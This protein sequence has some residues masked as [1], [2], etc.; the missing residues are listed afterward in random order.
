[1]SPGSL[2]ASRDFRL[3]L[4]GQTTSQLGT[5]VS[6]V[7]LPLLAVL[8]LQAT[9]FEVGLINAASTVAFA[10]V[11]LPAGVWLDRMRRRPVL[12]ASDGLR[13]VVL[14]TIPIAAGLGV[15]SVAQLV[16]VSLLTGFG[17]VFF[18]VG[19][20]SYLPSVIGR[21]RVLAGN[22]SLEF[23]R[24]S[25][26]VVGPGLGG[27]LVSVVSA[28]NV[29]LIQAVTFAVSALT[30]LG[31]RSSEPPAAV[32]ASRPRL[33]AQIR[34]GLRFVWCHP[35]LR[36]TAAASAASNLSFAL[37]SA[38]TILFMSRTL[39]LSP[40]AIGLILAGGSGAVMVG[41]ALTTR[42]AKAIGSARLIWLSL[43][44]TS[45]LTVLGVLAQPGWGV[46]LLLA[47]MIAGELGQ[48]VYA[49]TSVSLRQHI[50][51]DH[52]LGRV[53]ATMTVLIMGLFPVGA[54][55]GGVLGDLVGIRTTLL[56]ASAV[57][58]LAPVVLY[59]ALRQV[60]D[61]EDVGPG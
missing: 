43:A 49:I 20:R 1:M 16:V 22:A 52:F 21:D 26:Q 6:S 37:A 25:G 8:A 4:A 15:L 12:V 9:A 36:A 31:V 23:V 46:I 7:A 48:I 60:R 45:P 35:L 17:R 27:A 51:P 34:D 5:Q 32:D 14:A 3:L 29:V 61:I 47:G 44:V 56:V 42:V 39:G 24:A 2:F 40:A 30:L 54:L 19:Y 18:D 58:G 10:L 38:V 59:F 41:A 11:G 55:V 53:N 13:A 33:S 28:A 50:C 57:L